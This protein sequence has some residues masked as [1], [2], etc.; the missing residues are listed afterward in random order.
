MIKKI[1]IELALFALLLISILLT[2]KVDLA[3]YSFFSKLNYG[4]NSANLKRVFVEITDLGDS[5]WYFLIFSLT[6]LFC[7]L[8]KKTNFMSLKVFSYFKRLSFFGFFYLLLVGLVTQII[9]HLIG[10]PRPNHAVLDGGFE[11]NFF[12]TESAFHSFPSGHSSTIIALIIILSLISP[13]LKYFFYLCGFLIAISRVVVGAHYASDVVGGVLV[14]IIVYKTFDFYIK[15]KYPQ[16]YWHDLRIINVS[17]LTTQIIVFFILAVF[18]SVSPEIDIFI[19]KYFYY[20]NN[21]FLIQNYY[22]V[23]IFFRKILLPTLLLYVFI[24]PIISMFLPIQK[25]YFDYKFSL[26]DVFVIWFSGI[27][28]MIL[29]V[30]VFL[31]N[32]WGR[33]RPNDV[34][35]F[36]GDEKFTPWYEFGG[37]CVSNC[38]FVSGDASVGFLLILFYFITKK[39]FYIYLAIGLGSVLGL[40]RIMAGGHFFSDIIF[41]QIVVTVS[42]LVFFVLY[43]RFY[44]K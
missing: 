43:K 34:I 7:Y 31:K 12:T 6:I 39:I 29:I 41:A 22:F 8:G 3:I 42:V 16:I 10:R 20:G 14:A 25:I 17:P 18:V 13:N 26:R 44:D 2:Y 4:Y 33:E 11:F 21:Q 5:F 23:S 35:A 30:N 40:I 9:K 24:A 1:K 38:S 28:T 32:M 36:G 19:S 27:F 37:G 15:K